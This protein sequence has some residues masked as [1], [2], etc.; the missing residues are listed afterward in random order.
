[1]ER[2]KLETVSLTIGPKEYSRVLNSF[3]VN[4]LPKGGKQDTVSRIKYLFSDK[5]KTLYTE[6][7]TTLSQYGE[8]AAK[9]P[10]FYLNYA[11][12]VQKNAL[13]YYAAKGDW[14]SV[15]K[16]LNLIHTEL[17]NKKGKRTGRRNRGICTRVPCRCIGG[18]CGK[19]AFRCCCYSRVS[20]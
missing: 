12:D 5:A 18:K 10:Y 9:D 11:N 8:V 17:S 2:A 13:K 16:Y 14:D 3:D 1:M 4:N 20:L 7:E 19:C 15:E 6:P